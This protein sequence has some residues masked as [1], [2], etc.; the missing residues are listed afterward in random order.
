MRRIF[1]LSPKVCVKEGGVYNMNSNFPLFCQKKIFFLLETRLEVRSKLV[2]YLWM[3]FYCSTLKKLFS[4]G[5]LWSN[6]Y[7]FRVFLKFFLC[8]HLRSKVTEWRHV[9]SLFYHFM[10]FINLINN[11][12]V[13]SWG[14]NM[15]SVH[16]S[17]HFQFIQMLIK[18]KNRKC[19]FFGWPWP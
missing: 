6:F 5:F 9:L 15:F 1:N 10:L 14:V 18:K 16:S 7:W 17:K 8:C 13:I 12:F 2:V 11:L 4:V 3:E 19:I